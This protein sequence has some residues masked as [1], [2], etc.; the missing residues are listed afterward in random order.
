MR[1]FLLPRANGQLS[2]GATVL[3]KERSRMQSRTIVYIAAPLETID[4]VDRST[5]RFHQ[6]ANSFAAQAVISNCALRC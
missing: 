6:E 3:L 2:I 1:S 5:A 4:Q